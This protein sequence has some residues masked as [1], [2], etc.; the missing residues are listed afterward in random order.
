MVWL[1]LA[2]FMSISGAESV[3]SLPGDGEEREISL[4]DLHGEKAHGMVDEDEDDD[5]FYNDN[6]GLSYEDDDTESQPSLPDEAIT[7]FRG[8][9]CARLC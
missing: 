8:L 7:A 5:W 3:I 9:C 4:P 2:V 6:P 1:A